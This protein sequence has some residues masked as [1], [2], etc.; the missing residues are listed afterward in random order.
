MSERDRRP[1]ASGHYSCHVFAPLVNFRRGL[2]DRS[3]LSQLAS[4]FSEHERG[5]TTRA[6]TSEQLA[7]PSTSTAVLPSAGDSP[8]ESPP[9]ICATLKIVLIGDAGVGKTSLRQRLLTGSFTQS[10]RAT[11]GTDYVSRRLTLEDGRQVSLSV[12][13]TAGQERFRSLGASFYRGADA[14]ILVYSSPESLASITSWFDEFKTRCPVEDRELA[15]FAWVAVGNKTDLWAETGNGVSKEE[16]REVLD[17]LV[18]PS[19]QRTEPEATSAEPYS[20]EDS[21]LPPPPA[22][23]R[24]RPP[25]PPSPMPDRDAHP[26]THD[27]APSSRI[28]VLPP[29][30]SDANSHQHHLRSK[31]TSNSIGTHDTITSRSTSIYHDAA[32][33]FTQINGSRES[34]ASDETITP[35]TP[36]VDEDELESSGAHIFGWSAS[37]EEFLATE[38][39]REK[40][41]GADVFMSSSPPRTPPTLKVKERTRYRG[42]PSAFRMD[43]LARTPEDT[44]G[45]EAET[46]RDIYDYSQDGIKEFRT[47]AKTGEGVSDV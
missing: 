1:F 8:T 44:V 12:W 38:Q 23:V 11:I 15:D 40:E 46:P 18:L 39:T 33:S 41:R 16:S 26:F 25:T 35:A 9:P 37:S 2:E 45:E 21:D 10:Y 5:M 34:V 31:G 4:T 20:V 3:A 36:D 42:G 7:V 13:D 32:S 43:A 24:N 47:S 17:R 22:S 29:I 30:Q 19:R 14:A 6:S 27:P 28:D